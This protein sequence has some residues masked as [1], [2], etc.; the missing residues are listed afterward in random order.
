M[1]REIAMHPME[2]E[3]Q[4]PGDPSTVWEQ[5]LTARVPKLLRPGEMPRPQSIDEVAKW[6]DPDGFGRTELYHAPIFWV[7]LPVAALAFLIYGA[8][9]N[10][11][12]SGWTANIF[13]ETVQGGPWNF[14]LVWVGVLLWLLIAV[15]VLALRAGLVAPEVRK[16]NAWIFAHG[17]PCDIHLSPF[18][19]SD[20]EGGTTPTWIAIDHRVPDEQAG[21]IVCAFQV[22]LSHEKVQGNLEY[23]PLREHAVIA[24]SELFGEEAAGGYFVGRISAF[25]TASELEKYRW[26][27]VTPPRPDESGDI[28]T[29]NG[30]IEAGAES[31]WRHASVT[32]VP[33][34]KE[35][36][37]F[38]EKLRRQAARKRTQGADRAHPD[39]P[40]SVPQLMAPV[41]RLHAGDE[42]ADHGK[43]G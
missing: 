36:R 40:R 15:G 43:N 14:W 6:E 26:V 20:G 7:F 28:I 16:D 32:T 37:K 39:A 11:D 24:S 42:G 22:W 4:W 13:D 12:G 41:P 30:S 31:G 27:I 35:L 10:A 5:T 23:G 1:T 34:L 38:R 17:I 8:I 9:T 33:P 2:P 25:G 29:K 3:T 19:W 18:G 21:R